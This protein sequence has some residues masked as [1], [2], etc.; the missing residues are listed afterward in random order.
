[1]NSINFGDLQKAAAEQGFVNPPIGDYLMEV[2]KATYRKSSGGNDMITIVLKVVS[3]GPHMGA[4]QPHNL[5]ASPNTMGF[6]NRY[7]AALGYDAVTLAALHHMPTDQALQTL[8]PQLVGRRVVVSIGADPK[9]ATRLVVA[10]MGRAPAGADAVSVSPLTPVPQQAQ[11][12]AVSV[13]PAPTVA[14]APDAT[15]QAPEP[16]F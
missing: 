6:F 7:M 2:I 14:P 1:M 5:V 8:A 12:A 3:P 16:P 15:E 11:S 9:D 13:P 10:K 4:T